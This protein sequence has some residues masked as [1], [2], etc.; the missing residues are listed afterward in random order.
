VT[1]DR[2][3]LTSIARAFMRHLRLHIPKDPFSQKA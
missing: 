3:Q 1:S 2:R